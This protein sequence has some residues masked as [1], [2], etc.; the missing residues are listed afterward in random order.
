MIMRIWHGWTRRE[1]AD[2]YDAML[3]NEILPGI[4]RI[5]G[6]LGAHLL[7]RDSG[8]GEVEF[9][10]IT[11]WDSWDAIRLFAGPDESSSVID[12]KAHKLLTRFDAH[13][14]HYDAAWGAVEGALG[15]TRRG[16]WRLPVPLTVSTPAAPSSS[17]PVRMS[18]QASAASA[19]C[20]PSP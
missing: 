20:R 1:D 17:W 15:E 6:Y 5:S 9:I 3:K 2:T 16:R 11:T 10:T 18:R 14:E 7:R 13:S 4:H 8:D 12:P 19:R